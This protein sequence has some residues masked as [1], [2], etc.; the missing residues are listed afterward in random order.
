MTEL[1]NTEQETKK[2]RDCAKR[3]GLVPVPPPPCLQ[4]EE[5]CISWGLRRGQGGGHPIGNR[6]TDGME[7]KRLDGWSVRGADELRRSA[8]C[9]LRLVFLHKCSAWPRKR[10]QKWEWVMFTPGKVHKCFIL[11][12]QLPSYCSVVSFF[13]V[14]HMLDLWIVHF[15]YNQSGKSTL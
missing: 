12:V 1:P 2:G 15:C 5:C 8:W 10:G 6:A 14:Q 3:P 11:V 9:L 13:D 7:A 4:S